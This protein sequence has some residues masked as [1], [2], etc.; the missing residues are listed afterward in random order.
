MENIMDTNKELHII[1]TSKLKLNKIS[2]SQMNICFMLGGSFYPIHKNHIRT[3]D[4]TI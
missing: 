2:T 4:V 1:P 3:L